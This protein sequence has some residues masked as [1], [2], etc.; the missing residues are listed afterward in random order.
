MRDPSESSRVAPS[1]RRAVSVTNRERG[2]DSSSPDPTASSVNTA[3]Q[4]AVARCWRSKFVSIPYRA[5]VAAR[6]LALAAAVSHAASCDLS[7]PARFSRDASA[8]C[9][10]L[11]AKTSSSAVS[12]EAD[13]ANKACDARLMQSGCEL[14]LA[15]HDCEL[16][17]LVG[18]VDRAGDVVFERAIAAG[19]C[20]STPPSPRA[21]LSIAC[22]GVASTCHI[23][24]YERTVLSELEAETLVL[25]EVARRSARFAPGNPLTGFGPHMGYL[26]GAALLEGRLAVITYGEDFAG[27]GC[28]GR[29]RPTVVFVD[30]ESGSFA[31]SAPVPAC[32]SKIAPD[33]TGDGFIALYQDP[34]PSLG[35]FS[36][37]GALLESR[38]IASAEIPGDQAL[39]GLTSLASSRRVQAALTYG[40]QTNRRSYLAV[41][42]AETLD[43]VGLSSPTPSTLR[44]SAVA[45]PP[46][47]IV[48]ADEPDR[49]LILFNGNTGVAEGTPIPIGAVVFSSSPGYV[50]RPTP[51]GEIIFGTTGHTPAVV[52]LSGA[53]APTFLV[54]F[55]YPATA[56]ATHWMPAID[57]TLVGLTSNSE[58]ETAWVATLDARTRRFR[59]GVLPIG[60]GVISEMHLDAQGAIWA[61]LP[62]EGKVARVRRR[63]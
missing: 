61:L 28:A 20:M 30:L 44:A 33:P 3:F 35:R 23:D 10:N 12:V 45:E 26:G 14:R 4:S 29:E 42:D 36:R 32:T 53:S 21:I 55:E 47:I 43:L 15:L 24:V 6:W 41:F 40:S 31:E 48:T 49:R 63:P 56:W 17:P 39:V 8:E 46:T 27:F 54:F 13:C 16:E 51:S 34:E 19:D 1:C 37:S 5:G 62:W 58:S 60:Y 7:A 57:R 9:P 18:H 25:V 38:S 50:S 52:I 22:A 59:P 11:L 2:T